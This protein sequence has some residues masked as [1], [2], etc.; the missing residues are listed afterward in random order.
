MEVK[1][2]EKF[3]GILTEALSEFNIDRSLIEIEYESDISLP[4]SLLPVDYDNCVIRMQVVV[5]EGKIQGIDDIDEW[6]RS[7]RFVY[8]LTWK[9]VTDDG[10]TDMF[11]SGEETINAI[12]IKIRDIFRSLPGQ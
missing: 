12:A 5:P 4:K 7:R 9:S 8:R 11:E 2:D 10:R 6:F 1:S 3:D